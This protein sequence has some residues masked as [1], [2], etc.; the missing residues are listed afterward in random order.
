MR[1]LALVAA[2]SGAG[3]TTL[4]ALAFAGL[5]DEPRGAPRLLGAER[6]GLLERADGAEA[7][8]VDP[9]RAVWDAGVRPL[10]E[11]LAVLGPLDPLVVV[12]PATPL[13]AA[14]ARRLLDEVAATDPRGLDRVTVVLAEVHGRARTLAAPPG[15]PV[16]RLPYDRALAQPGAVLA[17]GTRLARRTRAAVTA[18]QDCCAE[19]LNR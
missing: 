17:D 18:W 14:D 7:D 3:A 10:G 4:A 1:T 12:A 13:G 8:T 19:L 11:V 2:S 9:E 6:G 16:L 15:A 5:R